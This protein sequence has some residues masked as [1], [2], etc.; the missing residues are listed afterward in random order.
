M[1]PIAPNM[2]GDQRRFELKDG[3]AWVDEGA[4]HHRRGQSAHAVSNRMEFFATDPTT[5]TLVGLRAKPPDACR[6]REHVAT[7]GG[8]GGSHIGELICSGCG[9]HRG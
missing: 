7:V 2:R 4:G 3:E 5:K 8:S 9:A 6:C 1:K